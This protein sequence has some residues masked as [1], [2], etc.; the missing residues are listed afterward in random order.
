MFQARLYKYIKAFKREECLKMTLFGS[1]VLV[2]PDMTFV[3][4]QKIALIF[5]WLLPFK[6]E[7]SLLLP[8]PGIGEPEGGSSIGQPEVC[9]CCMG[10]LPPK[11]IGFGNKG[12]DGGSV[13]LISPVMSINDGITSVLS[14]GELDFFLVKQ[15]RELIRKLN[16]HLLKF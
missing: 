8:L 16:N 5:T 9:E 2:R 3:F 6:V 14:I 1:E 10:S 7:L 11:Q 12:P 13:C 15:K 4:L